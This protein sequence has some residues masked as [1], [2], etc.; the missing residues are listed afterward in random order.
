MRSTRT[1]CSTPTHMKRR[2]QQNRSVRYGLCEQ[3]CRY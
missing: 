2:F 1:T 3:T